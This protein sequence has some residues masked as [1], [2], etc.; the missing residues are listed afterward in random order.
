MELKASER[1]HSNL[2]KFLLHE[3]GEEAFHP[4]PITVAAASKMDLSSQVTAIGLWEMSTPVKILVEE[5]RVFA[6]QEKNSKR[7]SAKITIENGELLLYSLQDEDE[8]IPK[9]YYV[10]YEDVLSLA[11]SKSTVFLDLGTKGLSVGR[12]FIL[13]TDKGRANNI[14]GHFTGGSGE[15]YLGTPLQIGNKGQLWER[16]VFGYQVSEAVSGNVAAYSLKKNNVI[17]SNRGLVFLLNTSRTPPLIG[18]HTG[19]YMPNSGSHVGTVEEGMAILSGAIH[20]SEDVK[21]IIVSQCGLVLPTK[22]TLASPDNSYSNNLAGSQYSKSSL[23]GNS[24]SLVMPDGCHSA[25]LGHCV[26]LCVFLCMFVIACRL[27]GH[28]STEKCRRIVTHRYDDTHHYD[29]EI[30]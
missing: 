13:L 17:Q 3:P 11:N 16:A 24:E 4:I 2:M 22:V 26:F 28:D 8:P 6:L 7:R 12:V 19:P 27:W 30:Y 21:D 25:A 23:F 9:A 20:W 18:I 14:H 5:G 15:S 29:E 10:Q 1:F